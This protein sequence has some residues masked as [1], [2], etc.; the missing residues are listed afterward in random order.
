M[1][2]SARLAD[3]AASE[4][5][6]ATYPFIGDVVMGVWKEIRCDGPRSSPDC[7]SNHN[8]GPKGYED[9][10]TLRAE[11]RREGWLVAEG[12]EICPICRAELTQ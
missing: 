7:L 4:N 8:D 9:A 12:E 6:D 3:T 2:L 11:A 5:P 10:R 1:R